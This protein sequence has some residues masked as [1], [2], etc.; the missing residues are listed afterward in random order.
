VYCFSEELFSAIIDLF[1]LYDI[2]LKDKK[3]KADWEAAAILHD[4]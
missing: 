1:M 4:A 3:S 2:V